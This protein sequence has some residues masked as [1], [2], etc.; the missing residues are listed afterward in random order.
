MYVTFEEYTNLGFNK[1]PEEKF[2]IYYEEAA[3]YVDKLTLN[4][5]NCPYAELSER[6]K[7]GICKIIDF[8][9]LEGLKQES[10]ESEA[11]EN[12]G[13]YLSGYHNQS[14]SESYKIL[15]ADEVKASQIIALADFNK[16]FTASQLY[17]GLGCNL[18]SCC[19]VNCCSCNC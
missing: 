13:K 15:S 9:Y 8:F 7:I 3:A 1:V 19:K 6:N 12:G 17:R 4:R 11:L 10:L 14:Y 2:K 5:L 16:F 18:C